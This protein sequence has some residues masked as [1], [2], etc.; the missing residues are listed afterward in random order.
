[1]IIKELSPLLFV[2]FKTFSNFTPN[3]IYL[4]VFEIPLQEEGINSSQ[5]T[6]HQWR[7]VKQDLQI[8]RNVS[9]NKV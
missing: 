6:T 9:L 2:D 8:M 1:M 5:N 3:N 4:L 7:I